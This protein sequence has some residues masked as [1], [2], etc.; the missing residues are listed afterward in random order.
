MSSKSSSTRRVTASST[1]SGAVVAINT[2]TGGVSVSGARITA[3]TPISLG[4]VTAGQT[5]AA[6]SVTASS[7]PT[8]TGFIITDSSYT[9]IDDTSFDP[10]GGYAKIIGTNFKTGAVAYINGIPLSTV[11]ISA[12]ELR[13]V[14]PAEAIGTYSLIVFNTD[15]SGGIY[16]G[17]NV[18]SLPAFTTN[19]GPLASFYETNPI[20]TTITATGDT[21]IT[22]SLFSGSLPVGAT[23]SSAGT[24]TG[25]SPID[26]SSTTYPFV[27]KA[28]DPQNQ[29][30]YRAFSITINTD[31]V[32]WNTPA[33]DYSINAG[34]SAI[35]PIVLDAS[36][37]AGKAISYAADTLPTGVTLSAG[38]I[39][40]S[41]TVAGTTSTVLTATAST[42]GRSATRMIS[43][44]VS[45]GDSNWKN[46]VLLVNGIAPTA[47]F[48]NDASNNNFQLTIAGDTKPSN[49]NPYLGDGYYSVSHSATPD[50]LSVPHNANFSLTSGQTDTFIIE[51][52]FYF[53]TVTA[54][55]TLFDKS[56]VNGVSFSNWGLYLNASKQIQ[57]QWGV[58]G[59]PGTSNIGTLT[60]SLIPVTGV[61]YHIAFVKSNADWAV[62]ANGTRIINY[63]G[64]NTAGDANPSALRIGYGI[65][66]ASNGAYFSGHIS[67][68][69]AWRG[70]SGAPYSATS[71]TLTVP[72]GPLTAIAGTTLLS[73]QSARF[74]DVSTAAAALTATGATL[75]VSSAIPFTTP[76]SSLGSA[77]FDGTGDFLTA[78]SNQAGFSMGTGDFT[79]ESWVYISAA[80]GV[81]YSLWGDVRWSSGYSSGWVTLINSNLT[82]T[83]RISGNTGGWTEVS[84]TATVKLNAWNHVA[85]SR[86]SGTFRNFINGVLSGSQPSANYNY[87]NAEPFKVGAAYIDGLAY[88]ITGYISDVRVVKGTAL[89]TTGFPLPTAPLAPVTNTQLLTLQYNGGANN[90]GFVDRSGFNN[91]ITKSGNVTQGTFSPFSQTGWS[92]YFDGSSTYYFPANAA[93]TLG[94]GAYTIEG[95]VNAPTGTNN[96]QILVGGFLV[97]FGGYSGSTVGALRFYDGS[98]TAVSNASYLIAT[99]N[100]N[101]FAIVRENTGT[102]GFKMY[103]NGILAYV[104][105]TTAN[106]A[107]GDMY[108][109]S[110]NT[111]VDLLTGSISNLRLVKGT[112]VYTTSSTTIGTQAFT[113]PTEPLTAIVNTTLLTAQSNRLIDNSPYN[114]TPTI[115]NTPKVQAYS[116][117]GGVTSVSAS[118][119]T[120]F[121]GT[122]GSYLTFTGKSSLALG[123]GDFTIESWVYRNTTTGAGGSS[124]A[125]YTGTRSPA[126][127]GGLGIKITNGGQIAWNTNS[128]YGLG[129]AV[130]PPFTWTHIAVTR[131]SGTLKWYINGV[132]DYS[133]PM[134]NNY[135][136]PTVAIGITDDPYYSTLSISNFRLVTGL[137][138]YT[139]N[140]DVPTGPLTATQSAGTNI[141]AITTQTALLTCQSPTLV[142]N[143]A[144]PATATQYGTAQRQINFNPFGI[145][146]TPKVAYIQS[147][148]GGSMYF[149]GIGDKL[150]VANYPSL[151]FKSNDFT[152]QAWVYINAGGAE[153]V[154]MT[155]GWSAYC[156]WC[157]KINT[158]N[159]VLLNLSVSGGAWAVSEAAIGTI[160]AGQWFHV[161]VTRTSGVIKG[162][163]NGVQGYTTDLTTSSLYD[164]SQALTIGGRSDTV[165]MLNGYITDAQLMNGISLY[166]TN[167]FPPTTPAT[168]ST[169]VG[170][171]PTTSTLLLSGISGGIIDAHASNALETVGNTQLST[172][173]PYSN[174]ASGKSLYFDG[175]AAYLK[176]DTVSRNQYAFGSG[177]LTIE[178]WV[179]FKDT[180][181]LSILYDQ[182]NGGNGSY[183]TL[184]VNSG[185]LYYYAN[186]TDQISKSVVTNQWYHV[187]VTRSSGKTRL[188]V[189]GTTVGTS[190]VNGVDDAYVY[191]NEA[192]RPVIGCS[193][194]TIGTGL[195]NGYIKDLRVTKGVARYITTF[196]PPTS[197][198]ETK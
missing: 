102:N 121:N 113:P 7:A 191:L 19:E 118:Y 49:F 83:S 68:V 57:L 89:Y 146:N 69:R 26:N 115:S 39:S 147:D 133:T 182:R 108:V 132:L 86:E 23:L 159:Q 4:V 80:P 34:N 36:S 193:G 165:S 152:I 47:S 142:D 173:S 135:S 156:P 20:S 31:V 140:F 95:W 149:D 117:F 70:T 54:Q 128:S 61:W 153:Q 48:N 124:D 27:V 11:F 190:A 120:K 53:N 16:L 109:G 192:N 37:A 158:S 176:A 172:L 131:V 119:S 10:T 181:T 3:S 84:S 166:R 107:S 185:L 74:L 144:I 167:F 58:S 91:I 65:Q 73:H 122:S 45:L 188:F 42:T 6:S 151:A 60:S 197:T 88:P 46:V 127:S 179:Y 51:G 134:A 90:A 8:V 101:H 32:T 87:N 30:S 59:A 126:A 116:P 2:P 138:V 157:I 105:T 38:T 174:A 162:F 5:A 123:T 40:G 21:P 178:M 64:L 186:S 168:P 164:G 13:V 52:W 154:I 150:T 187:A 62:F 145:T 92:N 85:V 171:K 1:V 78:P 143:S 12:T 17:L 184:Y 130:I 56:G 155:N 136:N 170:T 29:D 160:T 106:P 183:P 18:S 180:T 100:W 76:A 198:Y 67:N 72:T 177:D 114:F 189:N 79:C 148:N 97:G 22:Y 63:N 55:T 141:A 163:I 111:S 112:A 129:T 93:M 96:K 94:A 99:G 139:G 14:I 77:Y 195:L 15:G 196:T 103:V 110:V 82:V 169:M 194:M 33:T 43:W 104:G 28:T 66:G 25:T 24:I 161:A 81:A 175:A 35:N 9:N 137:A 50:Y 41:P 44:T 125:W 71:T 98:I 75:K